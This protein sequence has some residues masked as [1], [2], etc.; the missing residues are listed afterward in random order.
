MFSSTQYSLT[1]S[2]HPLINNLL[3]MAGQWKVILS[4]LRENLLTLATFLGVL[5]GQ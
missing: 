1:I 3:N 2:D 5:I 4:S